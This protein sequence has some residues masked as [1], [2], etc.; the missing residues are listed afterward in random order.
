MG[1]KMFRRYWKRSEYYWS[2]SKF[3]PFHLQE[4][5]QKKILIQKQK[6]KTWKQY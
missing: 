6:T 4:K 5:N 1:D 2:R 3:I